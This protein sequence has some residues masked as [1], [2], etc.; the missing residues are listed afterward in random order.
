MLTWHDQIVSNRVLAGSDVV[1]ELRA[2]HHKGKECAHDC[3]NVRNE[4]E[5]VHP[6][7]ALLWG[8]R[9]ALLV[10]KAW[11]F[12]LEKNQTKKNF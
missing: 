12:S 6:P 11:H 7:R 4:G 9:G 2:G 10:S 1:G 5:A 8:G 3:K